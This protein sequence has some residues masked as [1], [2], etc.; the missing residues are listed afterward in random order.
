MPLVYLVCQTR[1]WGVAHYPEW[2]SS[3]VIEV[4]GAVACTAGSIGVLMRRSWAR[5]IA[6]AA[7]LSGIGTGG[8]N[9]MGRWGEA[10]LE[11]WVYAL[12]VVFSA[13]V[14]ITLIGSKV[15][16]TFETEGGDGL[17]SSREPA[18]RAIRWTVL[19]QLVAIPMLLIFV[20]AQ[21][22]VPEMRIPALILALVLGC[23]ALLSMGRKL[24]GAVL[25]V[26]GGP[27]LLVL[28]A[29]TAWLAQWEPWTWRI[30]GYYACFWIPAGLISMVAGFVLVRPVVK[31]WKQLPS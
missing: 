9:L 22:V 6:L 7:A 29:L 17:W 23:A 12:T 31:L 21:P 1:G 14:L 27:A 15:R 4:F 30:V 10:S 8:L 20:F 13:I 11:A 3:Q 16:A 18:V 24:A 26:L 2:S 19:S 25:L 28:T 5:W